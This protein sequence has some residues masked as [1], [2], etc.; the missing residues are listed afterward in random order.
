[1]EYKEILENARKC[2]GPFCKVCPVCNGKACGNTVPGPGA[3]GPGS[4]F[5]RNYEKWQEICVNMDTI[6]ENKPVDTAVELFGSMYR[7][8]FF[9]APVGAMKMHYGD[10]YDD[11]EYNRILVSA[12]ADDGIAAFTGDGVNPAVFSGAIDAIRAANGVGIPTVKPWN[13]DLVYQKLDAA[14]TLSLIH[15]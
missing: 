9:A 12:C 11:L 1:M 10:K 7:Y 15:I 4:G 13:M 2:S 3:K 14:K 5:V 6:C 8:P